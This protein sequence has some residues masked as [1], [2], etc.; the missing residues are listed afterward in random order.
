MLACDPRGLWRHQGPEVD[1]GIQPVK[2]IHFG[3]SQQGLICYE[4]GVV[5]LRLLAVLQLELD[6]CCVPD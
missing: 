1:Y 6:S 3:A 2:E 4:V 5:W